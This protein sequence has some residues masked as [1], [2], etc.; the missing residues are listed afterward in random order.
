LACHQHAIANEA[1]FWSQDEAWRLGPHG[2]WLGRWSGEERHDV[3]WMPQALSKVLGEWGYEAE[4]SI[5]AWSERDWV[6]RDPQGKNQVVKRMGQ[7]GKPQRMV[8]SIRESIARLGHSS[9]A[10]ALRYQ[11]VAETRDAE[12]ASAMDQLIQR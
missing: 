11:H 7:K 12:V 10:A 9:P 5:R 6:Q 4:A 8:A 1:K 3:W 2:G